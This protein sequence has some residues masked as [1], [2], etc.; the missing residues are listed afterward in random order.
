[1]TEYPFTGMTD[2]AAEKL[3]GRTLLCSDDFFGAK[4][5]LLMP[6][7]GNF[8][9]DRFT[10]HGRWVDGWETRRRRDAGHEWCIIQLAAPGRI[11]GVDIDTNHFTGSQPAFASIDAFNIK[12]ADTD[13]VE[14]LPWVEIL[15]RTAL[16]PGV[17]NL[18]AVTDN[19]VYTHIRLNIFPDG[20]IARLRVYGE[21]QRDW[22]KIEA[23]ADLAAVLNGAGTVLCND[24]FFAHMDNLILPGKGDNNADG[25]ETRRSREPGNRDWVIIRLGTAGTI[26][27]LVV[28]TTGFKGNY[29]ESCMVEA[30][31]LEPGMAINFTGDAIDWQPILPKQKLEPDQEQVFDNQAISTDVFTHVRLSIF[32]DGGIRRFRVYGKPAQSLT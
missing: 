28:D 3:G 13:D 27:R 2:L 1:M 32:P 4:E 20:G 6:G 8:T 24:M 15:P 26:Q 19:G 23:D 9:E 10:D 31:R 18:K 17:Q 29:P 21:V 25:W 12:D 16:L 22:S 7:R 14:Q 11:A 5:N 30:C